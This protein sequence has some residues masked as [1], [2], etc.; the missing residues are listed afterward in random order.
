MKV[1]LDSE[2]YINYF[3]AGGKDM[4]TGEVYYWEMAGN[5]RL[6]PKK[7]QRLK[8]FLESNLIVG[9][10]SKDFDLPVLY[11]AIAGWSC[12][13]IKQLANAIIELNLK[14]WD[15]EKQFGIRVPDN[16]NHIDLIE[17]APGKASLKIYNGRMHGRRMQDLPIE[18]EAVLTPRQMDETFDYWENDLDAT[19]LLFKTLQKQ[20][21]LRAKMS[22]EYKMDLRSKSD[23]QVAEAV[24]KSEVSAITGQK[25]YRPKITPGAFYYFDIPKFI[26][27]DGPELNAV[28]DIVHESKFRLDGSGKM[29]LPKGLKD[30]DIRI[31]KGVYRLG[32]GGLHS[33]EKT[34]AVHADDDHILVD[35]DVTSYYPAIIIN[36]GLMPEHLG[37]PF[38]TV[39]K[40]LVARRLKAKKDGDKVVADSLKITINGSF[41]KFGS[42]WSAL[43]S[44][45]LLIQT[46][47]TGQ[48][49]LLMLI[50]WLEL[51]GIPVVSAN[52]D[53]I[54]IRCPKRKTNMMAAIIDDW[55]KATGFFTE[56]TRYSAVYSRD[57][58]NYIAVKED[59]GWKTKGA[60]AIP[61]KEGEPMMM[62]NP[63]NEICVRAVIDH[64]TKGVPLRETILACDDIRR[65]VTV[66][67]VKGGAIYRGKYLGKAIRWYHSTDSQESIHYKNAN[68]SGTHNKVP[69][70]DGAMPIMELPD[71]FPSDINYQH[72]LKEA[73]SILSEIGYH[74][75]LS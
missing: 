67:T 5:E 16:L 62:K 23:A 59:G 72:Y 66:R 75:G 69:K 57:V 73:R 46:T 74:R 17:V 60:Y 14:P 15:V 4:A 68:A 40:K 13:K 39:Y 33:S 11:A 29:V 19:E 25:V 27:F 38:L 44:P 34:Q 6:S 3:L 30:L 35:R 42:K 20:I 24:I 58:N 9:F 32:I 56:E 41:G 22:V 47:I 64:I 8:R 53:G 54:V 10:N 7:R 2:V 71:E 31:G 1:A 51:E 43:C 70:S 36:Q 37:K 52:T 50:Q 48:L 65:F 12:E 26:E 18:P 45:K 55:E 63:T 49:S 28:L 61:E 21:D